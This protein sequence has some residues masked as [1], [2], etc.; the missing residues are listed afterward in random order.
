MAWGYVPRGGDSARIKMTE[1]EEKR[2]KKKI[3]L[4]IMAAIVVITIVLVTL[5]LTVFK[6]KDPKVRINAITLETFIIKSNFL[7]MSLLLDLTV[8]N[9]N[10]EEL[11]YSDS[12]IRLFYYGDP[13]GQT[14]IPAG[15]IKSK[16][17]DN[18]YMMLVV[19]AGDRVRVNANLPGN[20]VSGELPMVA[21]TTVAGIVKVLGVF[22]HHAVTTSHCDISIFIANATIQS[23]FCRH[24]MRI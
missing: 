16:G 18:L 5:G 6:T 10:R 7:N 21:T 14:R 8:H 4:L 2:R 23:F 11:Q 20:I 13:V 19:E 12:L 9:P 3:C 22:K 17:S 1:Q 15:N 24:G